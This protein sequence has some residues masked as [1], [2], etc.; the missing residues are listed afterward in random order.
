MTSGFIYPE[1][2]LLIVKERDPPTPTVAEITAPVPVPPA[3]SVIPIETG[4][5]YPE[6]KLSV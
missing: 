3:T 4:Y 1:P 6:P 5:R 2:A